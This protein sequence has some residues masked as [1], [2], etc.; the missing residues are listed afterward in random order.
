MRMNSFTFAGNVSESGRGDALVCQ[1]MRCSEHRHVVTS[2]GMLCYASNAS[3]GAVS[4][5]FV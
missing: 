2:T 3:H 1:K 5:D 4:S